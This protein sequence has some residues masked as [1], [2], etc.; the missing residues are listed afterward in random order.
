[1][2]LISKD[3]IDNANELGAEQESFVLISELPAARWK[4][5]KRKVANRNPTLGLKICNSQLIEDFVIQLQEV[6]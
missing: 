1:M 3:E 5:S 2:N 4:G 6:L